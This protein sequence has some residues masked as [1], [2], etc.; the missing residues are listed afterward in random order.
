[1][2]TYVLQYQKFL[3]IVSQT[4]TGQQLQLATASEHPDNTKS[5]LSG[6]YHVPKR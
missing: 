6:T 1:M 4:L 2:A 3:T 5:M